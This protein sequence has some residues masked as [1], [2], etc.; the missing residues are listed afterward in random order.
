MAKVRDYNRFRKIYRYIRRKPQNIAETGNNV[1]ESTSIT[2]TETDTATYTFTKT[3]T[4]APF[5]TATAF[6]SEGNES[7]NVNVFITAVSTTAVTIE[8]SAPFNGEV[9]IHAIQTL[10]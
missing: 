7:A 4:A 1:I 5:V 8:T 2:F 9:H 3:F 10:T 6:D